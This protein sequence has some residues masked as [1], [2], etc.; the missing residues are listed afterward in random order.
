MV[1][2]ENIII[3]KSFPL[4]IPSLTKLLINCSCISLKVIPPIE[5]SNP[6]LRL[7]TININNLPC[8]GETSATQ[9]R[10]MGS[11][12]YMAMLCPL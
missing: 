8:R 9:Q 7:I 11:P 6:L 1:K 5:L 10:R 12:S 3:L 2:G 4:V